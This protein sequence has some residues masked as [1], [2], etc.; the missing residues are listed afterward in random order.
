MFLYL[1]NVSDHGVTCFVESTFEGICDS[2]GFV[3]WDKVKLCFEYDF[4][5]VFYALEYLQ[6]GDDWKYL[7][8]FGA[9]KY[10]EFQCSGY[11]V[12]TYLSEYVVP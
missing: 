6:I 9:L 7:M 4:H 8:S 11:F 5:S 3:L 12:G 2:I 10:H 1:Q